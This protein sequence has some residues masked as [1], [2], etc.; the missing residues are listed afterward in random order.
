MYIIGY[1]YSHG[2]RRW[3]LPALIERLRVPKG[4]VQ[5]VFATLEKSGLILRVD[6]DKTFV[7]ARDIETI[8]LSEISSSVR[9]EFQ[10]TYSALN[11]FI[12]IPGIEK[13]LSEV[14]NAID[15]TLSKETL[16]ALVTSH[17]PDN[18]KTI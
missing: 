3:T 16:K 13:I 9:D 7:P 14:Q 6:Y 4:A 17:L 1:D 18:K 15:N 10:D 2:Q 5:D 8:T 12:S 11:D